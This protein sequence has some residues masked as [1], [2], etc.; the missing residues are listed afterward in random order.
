MFYLI[1][2]EKRLFNILRKEYIQEGEIK[3]TSRTTAIEFK[4]GNN[5]FN[6]EK[7]LFVNKETWWG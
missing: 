6:F 1:H 5:K 2:G 4:E 3:S 7:R